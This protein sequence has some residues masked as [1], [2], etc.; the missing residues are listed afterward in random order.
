VVSA[1]TQTPASGPLAPVTTPPRS[2][3]P[4][5]MPGVWALSCADGAV[6]ASVIAMAAALKYKCLAVR[7]GPS[8]ALHP[9]VSYPVVLFRHFIPWPRLRRRGFGGYPAQLRSGALAHIPEKWRP[10]FRIGYAPFK[11]SWHVA[12]DP[13]A[14]YRLAA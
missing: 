2:L 3:V 8:D 6:S 12:G 4:M 7:I 14:G 1:I 11:N 9:G 5:L 13:T 10:V